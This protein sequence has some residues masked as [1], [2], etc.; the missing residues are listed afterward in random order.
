MLSK[1]FFVF[2]IRVD[3]YKIYESNKFDKIFE[4]LS[5]LKNKKIEIN[6]ILIEKY[7]D[8]L[9]NPNFE[10]NQY[11]ITSTGIYKIGDFSKRIMK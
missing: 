9:E 8:I 11:S 3:V 2:A 5:R 7:K 10:Q 1:K 4:V 6:I